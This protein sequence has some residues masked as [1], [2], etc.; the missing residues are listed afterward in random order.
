MQ[1]CESTGMSVSAGDG[2]PDQTRSFKKVPHLLGFLATL[3]GIFAV[4]S[5]EIMTSRCGLIVYLV[6]FS[7]SL[8]PL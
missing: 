6:F 3:L 4:I 7:F 2:A 8:F 5:G 1:H